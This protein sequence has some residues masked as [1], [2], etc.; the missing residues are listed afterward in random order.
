MQSL[1]RI[2]KCLILCTAL[3]ACSF[4]NS[5]QVRQ[6]ACNNLKSKI[7]FNAATSDTR[8]AEIERAQRPLDQYTYDRNCT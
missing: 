8:R 3:S 4:N 1:A 2:I 7:I 6:A 5:D